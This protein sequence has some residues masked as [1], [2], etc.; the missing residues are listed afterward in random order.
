MHQTQ[1]LILRHLGNKPNATYRDIADSLNV[2]LTGTIVHHIKQLVGHGFLK[3]N[4][5]WAVTSKAKQVL[6]SGKE[7]VR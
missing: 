4:N 5:R 1:I 6:N 3:R 7:G 2:S